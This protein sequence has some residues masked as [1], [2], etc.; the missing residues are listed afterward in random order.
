M[1]YR[2]AKEPFKRSNG[3]M[4]DTSTRERST[5]R[6]PSLSKKESNSQ[7]SQACGQTTV[8]LAPKWS[9]QPTLKSMRATGLTESEVAQ[10]C[11]LATDK[12]SS[13]APLR[14]GS[15][16]KA[17]APIVLSMGP[18]PLTT[19]LGK[20]GSPMVRVSLHTEMVAGTLELLRMANLEVAGSRP[21]K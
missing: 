20:Q 10:E 21:P 12:L 13:K 2:K 8:S 18:S 16:G 11:S 9:K 14:T 4:K 17:K 19:V 5:V 1:G 7:F 6:V 3:R 15:S